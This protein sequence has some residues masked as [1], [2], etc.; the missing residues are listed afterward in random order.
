MSRSLSPDPRFRAWLAEQ[1]PR[2]APDELLTGIMGQVRAAPQERGWLLRWPILRFAAPVAAGLVV[3]AAVATGLFLANLPTPV[4]PIGSASPSASNAESPAP[5]FAPSSAPSVAPATAFTEWTRIDL[6]DPAP[7]VYGGGTPSGLVGFHGEY[8]AVGTVNAS[9]CADGDPSL[10]RG[11][12]WTSS[13]GST[14]QLHDPVAAF[15]HA[16]LG[17]VVTDGQRL[18]VVGS[19]AEPVPG[20]T[21]LSVP[22]VWVS[23]D[24][25]TWQRAHGPVPTAI[26]VGAHGFVGA[27][28][29]GWSP[30]SEITTTQFVSSTNGLAWTTVSDTFNSAFRALAVNGDGQAIAAGAISGTPRQDGAPTT[31]LIMWRSPDGTSWSNPVTVLSDA[32]PITAASD[33]SGF[34]LVGWG[35]QVGSEGSVADVTSVWR[36][37]ATGLEA[38]SI[39]VAETETLSAAFAIGD[40]LV[41]TGDTTVTGTANA[42][43]WISTDG[44]ATW[45]R[46]ADQEAF[47]GIENSIS[48]VVATPDGLLAVGYRWDSQTGHP[49]P[50]AW[51]ARAH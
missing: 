27:M 12:F 13:D 25:E 11:V 35:S 1:G 19:S 16:S 37:T 7:D 18:V 32:L 31:D 33:R 5:T 49:M 4:G 10:N 21:G 30:G 47:A 6:P 45:G 51:L 28:S 24:A 26:A 22:A 8:V 43:I 48:G 15:A 42:M 39:P 20:G 9:C 46:V 29:Q 41:V 34:L 2:R 50:V 17:E 38:L 14:W 44:G 40:T 23:T 3:V 36:V